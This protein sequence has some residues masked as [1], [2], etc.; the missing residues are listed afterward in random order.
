MHD[1]PRL[2]RGFSRRWALR[3][4]AL[5][6]FVAPAPA[7]AQA[8]TSVATFDIHHESQGTI[9]TQTLRIVH[10]GARTTVEVRVNIIVRILGVVVHRQ[11]QFQTEIWQGGRL[12]SFDALDVENGKRGTVRGRA[13]GDKFVITT[14]SGQ[15]IEA[16]ATIR[17]TY[18]WSPEI[19]KHTLLMGTGSGE[20]NNVQIA[21]LG[22]VTL[23]LSG[24]T[25][26]ALH[27]RVSGDYQ[28]D[29]WFSPDGELLQFQFKSDGDAVTFRRKL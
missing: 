21:R 27:Y 29:M 22:N 5:A 8:R 20:L 1:E 14:K 6:L 2:S 26:P 23:T 28:R 19:V 11:E 13:E 25:L 7:V 17:T 4:L 24:R 9:G 12:Q 15:R 3:L 18:P 10:D 16:P